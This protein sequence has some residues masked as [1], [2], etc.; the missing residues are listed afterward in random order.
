MSWPSILFG[1]TIGQNFIWLSALCPALLTFVFG[2]QRWSRPA[3]VGIV[4]GMASH[5]LYG[6]AVGDLHPSFFP[7]S[8]GNIWLGTNAAICVLFALAM[9]GIE[10]LEAH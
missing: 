10:K 9:I 1:H 7:Q 6:A 2:V 4:T 5:L 8:L 3:V